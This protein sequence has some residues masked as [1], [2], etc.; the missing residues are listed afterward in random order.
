MDLHPLPLFNNIIIV[1]LTAPSF[2]LIR[3]FL[4]HRTRITNIYST[5]Q[6]ENFMIPYALLAIIYC[7]RSCG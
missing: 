2:A 5:Q 4:I 1:H 3:A 7:P 6:F